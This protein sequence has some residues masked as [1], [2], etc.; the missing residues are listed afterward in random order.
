MERELKN[1]GESRAAAAVGNMHR[2]AEHWVVGD[3][4]SAG[5]HWVVR[6]MH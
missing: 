4:H 1:K 5:E 3:M 6:D 2:V